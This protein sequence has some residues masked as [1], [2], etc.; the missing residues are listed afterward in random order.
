MSD[1]KMQEAGMASHVETL[2]TNATVQY[3]KMPENAAHYGWAE[4]AFMRLSMI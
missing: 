2:P 1:D 4:A 3:I